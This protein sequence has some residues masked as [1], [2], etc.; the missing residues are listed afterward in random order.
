MV[1]TVSELHTA[2]SSSGRGEAAASVS[3][4]VYLHLKTLILEGPTQWLDNFIATEE[5]LE[6]THFMAHTVSADYLCFCMDSSNLTEIVD[7]L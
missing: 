1:K 4:I 2:R 5:Q 7:W 3:D 6:N